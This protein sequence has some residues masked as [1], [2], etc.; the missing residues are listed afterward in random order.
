M[1]IPCPLTGSGDSYCICCNRSKEARQ[2]LKRISYKARRD[3]FNKKHIVIKDNTR[4]CMHY[5]EGDNLT[6][7]ALNSIIV[8]ADKFNISEEDFK[9][10]F[11]ERDSEHDMSLF[12]R[13][14]DIK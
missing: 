7:E 9:K 10:F 13:F 2:R 4:A 3:A 6:Q 11:T 5:F 12:R 1:N 8:V 14:G